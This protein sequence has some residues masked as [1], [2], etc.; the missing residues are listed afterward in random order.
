MRVFSKERF[1][2]DMVGIVEDIDFKWTSEC[3]G[4]EV[5][6]GHVIGKDDNMYQ[7]HSDWEIEV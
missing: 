5:F 2:N 7:S 6:N 3:D 1:L 4:E